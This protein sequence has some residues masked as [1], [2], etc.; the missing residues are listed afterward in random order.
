MAPG[1]LNKMAGPTRAGLIRVLEVWG[2]AAGQEVAQAARPKRFSGGVLTL[3]VVS[4]VWSQQ[5]SMLAPQLMEALNRELGEEM[6]VELRFS[7]MSGLRS[8]RGK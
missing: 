5:L 1:V 7:P 8:K 4:P 6:V 3:E 2:R